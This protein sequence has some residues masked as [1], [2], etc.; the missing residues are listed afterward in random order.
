MANAKGV[1]AVEGM[2]VERVRINVTT[3]AKGMAQRDITVEAETV[4]RA[5]E[6]LTDAMKAWKEVIM[7]YGIQEAK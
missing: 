2:P 3:N 7:E 4:E 6:L 5:K 1:I